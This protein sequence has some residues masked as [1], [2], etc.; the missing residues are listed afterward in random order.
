M[1]W[2]YK[3][4]DDKPPD[5]E[6]GSVLKRTDYLVEKVLEVYHPYYASHPD[7]SYFIVLSQSCDLVRRNG[8]PCKAEYISIAPVRPLQVVLRREF[9]D[10]LSTA[11]VGGVTYGSM[12]LRQRF[13][14]F[15]ARLFNNNN[16]K[17]FFLQQQ[18]DAGLP[19][20]ACAILPLSISLKAEHYDAFL[21]ARILNLDDTFQAK[22]G[23]LIGQQYSRVGTRDWDEEE[24]KSKSAE[25]VNASAVW[26]KDTD[27]SPLR[28]LIGEQAAAGANAKPVDEDALSTLIRNIPSKKDQAIDSIFEILVDA[29][30]LPAGKDPKKFALRKKMRNNPTFAQFFK[31]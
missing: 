4:G 16:P 31:E 14:E 2:T 22:L 1:H 17:Y 26:V 30:L 29:E 3:S 10:S 28:K 21:E 18:P 27:I 20:H 9:A 25:I 24:I 11:G 12:S 19:E 23:W 6:Q 7:N 13:E 5:L 15:L 8:A